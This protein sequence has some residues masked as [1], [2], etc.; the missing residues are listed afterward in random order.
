MVVRKGPGAL[1]DGEEH[2][3]SRESTLRTLTL[4][5]C[6]RRLCPPQI[7]PCWSALPSR[8]MVL[9]TISRMH[10]EIRKIFP[11]ATD[12]P[13][14]KPRRKLFETVQLRTLYFYPTQAAILFMHRIGDLQQTSRFSQAQGVVHW[15]CHRQ[16]HVPYHPALTIKSIVQIDSIPHVPQHPELPDG[17]RNDA[18]C[19]T[20]AF[21][22]RLCFEFER[23]FLP[24]DR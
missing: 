18:V 11:Y 10:A 17:S 7:P 1:I 15:M 3:R 19:W 4:I 23:I 14:L 2:L 5:V 6:V 21:F 9:V 22:F 13:L 12:R 24:D 16:S 20:T 8:H